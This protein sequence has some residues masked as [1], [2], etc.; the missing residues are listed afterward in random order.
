MTKTVDLQSKYDECVETIAKLVADMSHLIEFLEDEGY[1]MGDV[2]G[3]ECESVE[4]YDISDSDIDPD[5]S[6]VSKS[7]S[8]YPCDHNPDKFQS[9]K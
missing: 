7:P 9:E 8:H 1:D 2:L 4:H 5:D 3:C 6:D